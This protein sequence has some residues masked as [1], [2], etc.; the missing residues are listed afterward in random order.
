MHHEVFPE[1][2]M[3]KRILVVDDDP[4]IVMSLENALTMWGFEVETALDGMEAIEV[5][6]R[7]A[8]DGMILGIQMPRMNGYEVVRHLR[9]A[10]RKIPVII[11][12]TFV[13]FVQNQK[14]EPQAAYLMSNVQALLPKPVTR[15]ELKES[16]DRWLGPP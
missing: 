10:G 14:N 15:D 8:I 7:V 1:E 6:E 4:D 2:P 12:S 13:P 11:F 16:V 3:P 5:L 9:E